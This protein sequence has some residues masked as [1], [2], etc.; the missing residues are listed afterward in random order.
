[1]YIRIWKLSSLSLRPHAFY[2]LF[3]ENGGQRPKHVGVKTVYS[4]TLCVSY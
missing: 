3:P 1:M 4:F 2:V